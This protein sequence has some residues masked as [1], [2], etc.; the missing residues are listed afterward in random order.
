M[1][2]KEKYAE[3]MLDMAINAEM[4]AVKNGEPCLCNSVVNFSECEFDSCADCSERLIEWLKKEYIEPPVDWSK[5]PIDA[6][7]LV[8]DREK[9]KWKKRY[10]AGINKYGGIMAWE[11]GNTSW[12]SDGKSSWK[13]A[14]LATQKDLE[15]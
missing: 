9:E 2:N 10:F 5:V 8:R 12:T 7:I 14:K 6:P 3:M 11:F 1:T 13:F 4:F 15:G